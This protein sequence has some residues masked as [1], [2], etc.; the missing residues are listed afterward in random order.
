MATLREE[1]W[2]NEVAL[3]LYPSNDFGQRRVRRSEENDPSETQ[4]LADCLSLQPS[5]KIVRGHKPI[6][7]AKGFFD[8]GE[9][10]L[11]SKWW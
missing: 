7:T 2:R 8:A 10:G 3:L 5:K 11:L 6:V 1:G 4:V 9:R